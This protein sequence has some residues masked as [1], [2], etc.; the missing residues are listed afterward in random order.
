MKSII[1]ILLLF[2]PLSLLAQQ[3]TELNVDWIFG[4]QRTEMDAAPTSMWLPDGK[5]LICD[6]RQPDST[7]T[8][9][10]F[11]PATGKR[12]PALNMQKAMAS[13]KALIGD[14]DAPTVLDWPPDFDTNDAHAAFNSAGTQAFYVFN[15]DI[16]VLDLATSQFRQITK[17]DPIEE[18]VSFSPDGKS[19]AFARNND[20]YIYDLQNKS[21]R[22]LTPDGS[23]TLRN[24]T[25]SWVYWEEIFGHSDLGYW[26]SP[27]SRSIAFLQ[28]DDSKVST[29]YFMDFQPYQPRVIKQRYP[30]AG[31]TLP[32][33]KAGILNVANGKETW[34]NLPQTSYAYIVRLGW[35]P[36]GKQLKL[37]TLNRDQTEADL[38][39]VNPVSGSPRLVLKDEDSAWHHIYDTYFLKDG[40]R[41]VWI[42]ERSG[43]AHLYLYDFNGKLLNQVTKGDWAVRPFGGFLIY[44]QSPLITVDENTNW[45]Y[46]TASEK[47]PIEQHLYRI[48]LDGTGMERLSKEDGFH[49]AAFSD[50]AKYYTDTYSNISTVPALSLHRSDGSSV[51]TIVAAK[52]DPLGPLHMIY[53]EQMKVPASD[54]FQLPAQI[55]KPANFDASK[56][57]PAIVYVYGGPSSP[58]IQN[59]WNANNW[60]DP[61]FYDQLLL[62]DGYIVFSVDNRS[63]A[64]I[65]HTLE[66]KMQK[67]MYGDVELNDLVDAVKWL[68]S[69]PYVDPE[70]VGIWGWSGGGTYTLLALT[71]SKE[72]KAGI[73]IAPVTDWHHYDARWT[74][75]FM[76][77]PDENKEGYEKTSLV[78]TAKNLHGH[79]LIVHGTHDDNV[80]PQ[81][82]Q[83]FINELIN[84]SILFEAM[85]YPMRQHPIKDIPG[86]I[87]LYKTMLDFWKRNL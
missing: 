44:D 32:V 47:N 22:R 45:A 61:I 71:H 21:E 38:Y 18:A 37:Q 87:H 15:G 80:H 43:Y 39:L 6:G 20:L 67:D 14:K 26:W 85:V 13:L 42:S 28:M 63:S 2:T 51:A 46:F 19:I 30:K 1:I 50:D 23:E 5:L 59:A 9:E 34:I 69:Q 65:S 54:G 66:T 17:T 56:K 74:E 33:V 36:D 7:R 60:S 72:F 70:R 64:E 24:G 75:L 27:D 3:Q 68:K 31:E 53:A 40:K 58:S 57:Y 55:S 16:F 12:E 11:D 25:L 41:F 8:F 10:F 29:M 48:H 81:N 84:N 83:A 4:S 62:R 49:D 77:L 35:L 78:K 86:K 79:L 82:S 73:S 76:K 52:M